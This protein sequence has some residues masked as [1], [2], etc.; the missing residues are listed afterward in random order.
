MYYQD[1][2]EGKTIILL[3]GFLENLSM[4]KNVVKHVNPFCRTIAPDLFG[5]GNSPALGYI[6]EMKTYATAIA[7]LINHLQVEK[8]A[9][10]GHSM[11]GYVAMELLQMQPQ[12]ITD[13]VMLNSTPLSD[14]AEKKQHRERAIRAIQK[15][16]DAFVQMAVRNLFLPQDHNRLQKEIQHTIA[17][18]KKCNHQGI[19]ATLYGLKDRANHQQTF[20]DASCNKLV[21]AGKQDSIVP[22]EEL[23][24]SI[25]GSKAKILS[26]NG[27][28]MSHLEFPS[29]VNLAL[30]NFLKIS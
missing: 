25:L 10:V 7:Q 16:P 21:I 20:I 27:G 6:H 18:A 22:Y 9:I 4:W 15:F 3:H 19:I 30:A 1:Q 2:G 29:E 12:K 26:F 23:K 8:Y 13:L 14:S 17:E 11:G 24:K 5:H 28:H